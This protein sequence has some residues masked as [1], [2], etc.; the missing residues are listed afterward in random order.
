M[1]LLFGTSIYSG[2]LGL[3]WKRIRTLAGEIKELS[4]GLPTIST[5]KV[6][7]P[8]TEEIS[9]I[10]REIAVLEGNEDNDAVM[11]MSTLKSDLNLLTNALT[12]DKQIAELTAERKS[13]LAGNV[14][15]KHWLT[16]SILLS[17]GVSVSILGAFNTYMRTGRLFPGPH[18]YA[19]MG[20]TILWAL[21]AAMVPE[22]Q[23]G[24]EA[25]RVAHIGFNV[26]NVSL[27]AWQ[28]LTGFEIVLKVWEKTPW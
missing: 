19:G 1:M 2:V 7:S 26:L 21:A 25:A 4:Q 28:V 8:I 24:N 10:R 27:F 13:L 11:K 15:D 12:L 20:V 16:G 5:G 18:L 9:R 22:M 14:K 6:S 23:K 3:Q 17:A